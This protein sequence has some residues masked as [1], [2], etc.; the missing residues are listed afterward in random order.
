[1]ASKLVFLR[2][3]Y[4]ICLVL[5]A[6]AIAIHFPLISMVRHFLRKIPLAGSSNDSSFQIPQAIALQH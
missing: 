6:R 4:L 5:V 3:N 2:F 1:M